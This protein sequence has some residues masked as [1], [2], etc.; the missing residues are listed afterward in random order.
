MTSNFSPKAQH[1]INFFCGKQRIRISFTKTYK[2]VFKGKCKNHQMHQVVH[3]G[4]LAVK[5]ERTGKFLGVHFD[6]N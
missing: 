1:M 5:E 4:N 6:K 3:L 2:L